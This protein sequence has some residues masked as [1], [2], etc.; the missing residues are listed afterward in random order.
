MNAPQTIASQLRVDGAS[1]NVPR[2][3]S[4]AAVA[5]LLNAGLIVEIDADETRTDRRFEATDYARDVIDCRLPGNS[6]E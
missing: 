3:L 5:E 2:D 6:N 4:D 1:I